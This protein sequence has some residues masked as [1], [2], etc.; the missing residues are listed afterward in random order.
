[1][2]TVKYDVII[3]VN[4][5]SAYHRLEPLSI[6]RNSSS[7]Y[8]HT[9][10]R[11]VYSACNS[12][13]GGNYV[14]DEGSQ[15]LGINYH[16]LNQVFDHVADCTRICHHFLASDKPFPWISLPFW[17]NITMS[18]TYVHPDYLDSTQLTFDSEQLMERILQEHSQTNQ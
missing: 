14:N 10:L 8:M 18:T 1:M 4:R 2:M 5:G 3:S 17:K 11:R 9:L 16:T 15:I 12:S 7:W 6:Q 13:T